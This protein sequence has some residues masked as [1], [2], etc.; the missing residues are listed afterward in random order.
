MGMLL[1]SSC[2]KS[3]DILNNLFPPL[4]AGASAL[5]QRVLC[6]RTTEQRA[7]AWRAAHHPVF[8]LEG[9]WLDEI[10]TAVGR[11]GGQLLTELTSRISS[12]IRDSI[13]PPIGIV[14]AKIWSYK[15]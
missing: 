6:T 7:L 5:S 10:R 2:I 1:T 13:P 4:T 14:D 11:E 8:V 12:N 9:L 15:V 3:P